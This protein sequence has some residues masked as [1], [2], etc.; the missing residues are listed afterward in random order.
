MSDDKYIK[1]SAFQQ[2]EYPVTFIIGA[3]GV[4]KTV[5]AVAENLKRCF[6]A[7]SRFIYL[8]RYQS[9]IDNF[10][11]NLALLSEL[12]GKEVT[13]DKIADNGTQ[14]D[15]LLVDGVPVCFIQS[16]STSGKVKTN[17]F[18]NVDLIVYDEFID[19]LGRELKNETRLFMSFAQ[20]VF[21]DFSK[22]RALFLA[23]ATNLYN[24]YF[25]DFEVLPHGRVTKFRQLGIKIIMYKTSAELD[26]EHRLSVLGKQVQKIEGADGSSLDNEFDNRMDDFLAKLDKSAQYRSTLKLGGHV[27]GLYWSDAQGCRIISPK[28]NLKYKTRYACTYDDIGDDWVML[29]FDSYSLLR[30]QFR[31]G[32][33]RFTNVKARTMF[34][35]WFKTG[36]QNLA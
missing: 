20:T 1:T 25:L 33:L 10:G 2:P 7:E 17:D 14:R 27:Y 8:R 35:R 16:L 3:R 28:P 12:V 13:R 11:L 32:K 9:E 15:C 23:N 4:G 34:M 26:A 36:S 31:K 18:S 30:N 29:T 24:C 21:R 22:Y 6:A 19:P 5:S